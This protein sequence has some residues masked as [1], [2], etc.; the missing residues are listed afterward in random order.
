MI[1]E[2]RDVVTISHASAIF[3]ILIGTFAIFGIN[4]QEKL[5]DSHFGYFWVFKEYPIKILN[6]A[7]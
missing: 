2:N 7:K 4:S 6:L 3:V 1:L 5:M